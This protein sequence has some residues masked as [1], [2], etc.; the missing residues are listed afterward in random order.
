MPRFV[1]LHVHSH[2]SLLDGLSKIPEMVAHTKALG[3]DALALTDHGVLYGAVEFYQ[4]C[5]KAGVKPII[6]METYVA[7]HGRKMKR[8]NIDDVRWHLILL[9]INN[10][11]YKNL[12]KLTTAA[13]LEGF[14]YK[15]RV[16]WELLEQY[17]EGLV[18]LSG[19]L[20]GE[21]ADA[22]RGRLGETKERAVLERA[23]QTFGNGNFYLEL[24]HRPTL[25]N[26]APLNER[27]LYWSKTLGLPIVATNDSH[28]L[29]SEDADAQDVLLCLQTKAK[30]EDRKRLSMLGEDFSLASPEIMAGR[31]ADHPEAIEETA[32]LADRVNWKLELGRIILPKFA[33]PAGETPEQ[34]LRALAIEGLGK[35][36]GASPTPEAL[37]RLK[38]ELGVIERTGFASYFLIVADIVQWAKAQGI[39]VGPGRGSAAGSLVSYCLGITN[40]DPLKYE[41]YFERFLNVDRIS[42]PDIDLDFADTRRNEVIHY[43]EEKY[44]KDRVAQIITFGTM[45]ARAAIRD[46]GRV[47]GIS[48][49]YCDRLAKMIPMGTDL[50]TAIHDIAD[51]R[52]LYESQPDARMVFDAARKVEHVVRHASTHA[53]GVVIADAPLVEYAPLQ[54]ASSDDQTVICQYSL[55]PVEDLGLLKVDFLGLKNLTIL[56]TTAALVKRTRGLVFDVDHLP[57][58]DDAA[59]VLLQRGE[60]MGIFQLES[61]GMTRYLKELKPTELED[62]IAM[63]SLYRPGPMELLPDYIARKHGS[64]RVEYLHPRLKPIT[65]KTYGVMVY[66]EQLM[67][68]ARDLAG[69]TLSEADTLR[70]AVGK[71]IK[72]LLD[73]QRSKLIAGM[74]KNGIKAATAEKIWTWVEPFARYAFNRSHAACYAMI[75]YQTAYA[76][77]HYPEEFMTALLTADEGDVDR[78]ALLVSECRR[79]GIDVLPPELNESTKHFTV[80]RPKVIRFGLLAIKQ[81]GSALVEA[82]I[83]ERFRNGAFRSLEDLLERVDHKDLNKK[84]LE[85]LIYVGV[86][87]MFADRAVLLANIS[88][89]L[90][91]A[92]SCRSEKETNQV[93]LFAGTGNVRVLELS[94]VADPAF[95]ALRGEREYLGL[96]LSDHPFRPFASRLGEYLTVTGALEE[97]V[98]H[99]VVI[100]GILAGV[101][102]IF[103]KK[104]DP[105]VFARLEDTYGS[106]DI[107]VFPKYYLENP[108]HWEND[109]LAVLWGTVKHREGALSLVVDKMERV[110]SENVAAIEQYLAR[111]FTEQSRMPSPVRRQFDHSMV[112]QEPEVLLF[113]EW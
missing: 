31:F 98:G 3:M 104:G 51:V 18:A 21:I 80:V 42:M 86:F 61:Q 43:A 79:M 89:L 90:D 88:R 64:K 113:D 65:E 24:Q 96:Y 5:K 102:R 32:R 56:E 82:I 75:A 34:R 71:K 78:I 17:H 30:K 16:D 87:D 85:S 50:E 36:F 109:V 22:V 12:I 91:F 48:Y 45:A 92:R 105:M 44:G 63:V 55:H 84:S 37:E 23:V 57:V 29:K 47:L 100:G 8:A 62:I 83:A 1:H 7:P 108:S 9:A 103:T 20:N 53:C 99:P 4:E 70:K 11:G 112:Q 110:S 60:T 26:Q 38:Y 111:S 69:F 19:C 10:T 54:Y 15:P 76:K 41:L 72:K 94:E 107:V 95:S 25:P 66:Q 13:H 68:M 93:S 14:Y 97:A 101:K 106:L 73:E 59:F 74:G 67:Q 40:I 28:Y 2:Y 46:C 49:S 77:A 52:T 33:V 6:G 27:L 39:V 58:D 35:R 81:V